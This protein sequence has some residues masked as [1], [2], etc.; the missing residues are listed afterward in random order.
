M[1]D[2]TIVICARRED[3]FARVDKRLLDDPELSWTAKGILAYLLGKP[4]DWKL[5][6][7]DIVKH[8]NQGKHA[9]R[10]ALNELRSFGYAEYVE[11]RQVGKFNAG[12][13]KFWN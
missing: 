5:R 12:I 7:S 4:K 3:P 11:V 13:W 9:V 1:Q 10:A 8:G 2:P 6:V